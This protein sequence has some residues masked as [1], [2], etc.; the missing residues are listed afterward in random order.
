MGAYPQPGL[1]REDAVKVAPPPLRSGVPAILGY[2]VPQNQ[3][4]WLSEW[5]Q[6][7]RQV[8]EP[9]SYLAGAVRGFFDSGGQQCCVITLTPTGWNSAIES[10]ADLD[11]IDLVLAPSLMKEGT[12]LRTSVQVLILEL[13]R[14][15]GDC[16]AILD[17][18]AGL[19]STNPPW[20][21]ALLRNGAFYGPWISV[22]GQTY[23]PPCGHMAGI[24]A[25][26]DRRAGPHRSPA[27]EPLPGVVKLWPQDA[28]LPA[29]TNL[30]RALPGRGIRVGGARTLVRDTASPW[31][32][33]AVRRLFMT[34]CRQISLATTWAAFEP[35]DLKLWI[36]LTRQLQSYFM[37]LYNRGALKGQSPREAFFIKCDEETNPPASRAEGRVIV[38]LGLAPALPAEFLRVRL[39]QAATGSTIS[40]SE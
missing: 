4:L 16:F 38:E 34:V 30:L 8:E 24:Y 29:A 37:D 20:D 25:R 5:S 3:A 19:L 40:V 9:D 23:L 13:C 17:H 10:L 2:G 15:R 27:N 14:Q 39:T 21:D 22:D 18:N 6:L 1:Y 36:R 11:A 26:C 7:S 28:A 31:S 12:E 32:F 35:N 33:I